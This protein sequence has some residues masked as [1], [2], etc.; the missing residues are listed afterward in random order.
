MFDSLRSNGDSARMHWSTPPGQVPVP[1]NA[2]GHGRMEVDHVIPLDK[3]GDPWDLANLQALCRDCHI[4]KTR[5]ENRRTP[6][7]AEKRWQKAGLGI[8][9]MRNRY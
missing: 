3:G 8:G 6:T 1:S 5:R 4:K 7:P 2:D 9:L